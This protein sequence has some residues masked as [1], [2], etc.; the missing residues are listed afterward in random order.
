MRAPVRRNDAVP[1]L[2]LGLLLLVAL[3]I[4]TANR[5]W[6]TD[7]FMHSATVR[8][9]E[10]DLVDPNHDMTGTDD[11]SERFNPYTA[12]LAATARTFD[13][14][15][16][17]VMQVAA[18]ANLVAFLVAFRLFVGELTGRPR[19]PFFA[20]LA[21]LVLWGV[22]P[23]RW[24]GFLN[25]NSIGFGLPWPSMFVTAVVLFV[26]YAL[27]RYDVSGSVWWLV[28]AAP[29]MAL[30]GLTHPFTF[31]W[32][33]VMLAALAFSRRLYRRDRVVPLVLAAV[34]TGGL[35]AAWPQYPFYQL[36][37]L[38]DAYSNVMEVMYE[39]VPLRVVAALPGFVVVAGRF[40]RDRR[41]P[42]ALML[43]GG[44]SLYAFGAVADRPS[45]GRMLPLVMLSAH[46]A[47]GI[48]LADLVERRRAANPALVGWLA[49]SLAV[50]LVG[51]AP[52]FARMVPR[53]LLPGSLA[54]EESLLPI[55]EP[56]EALEGALDRGAVVVAPSNLSAIAPAYGYAVVAP[57]YPSAFVDDLDERRRDAAAFLLPSA[58]A[59]DRT[60]I[61][62]RYGIAAVLCATDACPESIDGT[63]IARTPDW[64]LVAPRESSG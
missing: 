58:S 28:V 39:R 33:S 25:L 12:T 2:A 37:D 52:G 10:H 6:S 56:Y 31:M 22:D 30:A 47:I 3:G 29:G 11:P 18:L 26:G 62:Q 59:S 32:S 41:D 27:L 57:S 1:Y 44:L 35:L 4:Q 8:A 21:T 19:V 60:S 36:G 48:L 42:L 17:P 45:F 20:L 24:S 15:P 23:W 40:R 49:A 53:G 51:A 63:V 61:A 46:I 54:S 5:Q 7:F 50:G 13:V 64:I 16:T 38:D 9:L 34:V 43:I 14:S 55:D